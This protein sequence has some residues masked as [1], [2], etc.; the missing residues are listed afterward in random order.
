MYATQIQEADGYRYDIPRGK[1]RKEISPVTMEEPKEK[2]DHGT[3]TTLKKPWN[4]LP[5]ESSLSPEP[6]QKIIRDTT[7]CADRIQVFLEWTLDPVPPEPEQKIIRD[8]TSRA[9]R[10]QAFLEWT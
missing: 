8:A 9:A 5:D 10:I 6:E 7:S 3:L 4:P 1:F 2:S